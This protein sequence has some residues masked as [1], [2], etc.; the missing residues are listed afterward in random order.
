MNINPSYEPIAMTLS[1]STCLLM[2]LYWFI[3]SVYNRKWSFDIKMIL[4]WI[5]LIF[6][7]IWAIRIFSGEDDWICENWQRVKHWNPDFPKPN[8]ECK[9]TNITDKK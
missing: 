9:G 1:V 3:F 5:I 7:I 8:T 2:L 4:T 6:I